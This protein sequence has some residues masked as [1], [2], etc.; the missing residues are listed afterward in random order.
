MS[1]WSERR[2]ALRQHWDALRARLAP[3]ASG[4][5]ARLQ[6]YHGVALAAGG[7]LL[8]MAVGGAIA[9]TASLPN[10]REIRAL[11]EAE[12]VTT[13]FDAQDQPLF[14]IE[15]RRQV[16]VPLD[17]MS[18][19]LI[20]A[21]LAVE[22]IRFYGHA[23]FDIR[24]IVG[25]AMA[26]L[27]EG[28]RA[29]GASTITQQLARKVFL[30]DRKTW[31]RKAREL[32]LAMRMER[33]L[34]KDQILE[35]YLNNVYF[36]HG[37]YGAEAA[38]LGYFDKPAKELTLEEATLLA[39]L[40]QAP[41]AYAPRS[42]PERATA[43]RK[44]VLARMVEAGYLNEEEANRVAA[45]PL[46]LY[47]GPP[48]DAF[49]QYFKNFVVRQLVQRFGEDRVFEEGLRVFTTFDPEI[50][51][52]AEK[53]LADGLERIEKRRGYTHPRYGRADEEGDEEEDDAAEEGP[54]APRDSTPYLQGAIVSMDPVTG[55]IRAL[56][57]GRDY[58]ESPFDRATQA[59]RQPGSAF[60]PFV[61]VAALESGF[62]PATLLTD[63]DVTPAPGEGWMPEE[64]HESSYSTMTMQV[65]LRTSSNRA[66]VRML[67]QVGLAEAMKYVH[68]FGFESAPPV[69]SVVLGTADVSVL[70]MA[71]AYA[72]FA[73]GGR[74]PDPVAIRRVESHDGE[75]LYE[76][77]PRVTPVISEVGAFLMAQMLADTVNAGTGYR[78]RQEGFSVPAGG[79]TGT[80]DDFRDAWFVGFTPALVTA[81]W[82]GFDQPKQIVRNG[83]G[84]DLAAPTWARFM[85]AAVPRS[86]ELLAK[87]DGKRAQWLPQPKGVTTARI[88][89][90]SGD[91]AAPGC[92]H[93]A[94]TDG[95]GEVTE[96]STV[97][98]AYFR[99]GTEPTEFCAIHPDR[100][101]GF[102]RGFQRLFGR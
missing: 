55:H 16:D 25:A 12:H 24:R 86:Q 85:R 90:I 6:P 9:L 71:N 5:R 18:S 52:S 66:A 80:T 96:R 14:E 93:V 38:S 26:N 34:S 81:V 22:D 40:I 75:L 37:Y 69:P 45:A 78:V 33:E 23:G 17:Q 89:R 19:D 11:T 53:A 27:R 49:G 83:F 39:G 95:D 44:V 54:P 4:T 98:T 73:N 100:P 65:A 20:H 47:D 2:R 76:H 15:K 48:P 10:V 87:G 28:D 97:T 68:R 91:L 88:C 74:L 60:K 29:Q 102:W 1:T 82:V 42:H 99:R 30:D 62:T 51:R 77:Q 13:M 56:V 31:W 21:V 57:G 72:V 36:G 59:K 46:D 94:A 63:L 84:G 92:E 8:L 41:S 64:A 32:V 50:Q 3:W 70:S 7:A 58:R 61:Y 35:L 67:S 79:K 101:A 43:R